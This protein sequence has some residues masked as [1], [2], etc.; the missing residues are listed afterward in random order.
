FLMQY[1]L[2]ALSLSYSEFQTGIAYWDH[3]GGFLSGAAI[4]VGMIVVLKWRAGRNRP[5]EELEEAA[6]APPQST[7]VPAPD[8]AVQADPV[9][10]YMSLRQKTFGKSRSL[11]LDSSFAS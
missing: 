5:A 8:P 11:D 9:A 6:M 1:I 10:Q 4:V 7:E 3:I 2:G